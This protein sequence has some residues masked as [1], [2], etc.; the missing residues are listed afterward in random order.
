MF[1]VW[2]KLAL[3]ADPEKVM[4]FRLSAPI[5]FVDSLMTAL[6]SCAAATSV[7]IVESATLPA[8][9]LR[10]HASAD[11]CLTYTASSSRRPRSW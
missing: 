9:R 4:A 2:P 8:I 11:K 3:D 1:L 7:S 10:M 6:G 5:A